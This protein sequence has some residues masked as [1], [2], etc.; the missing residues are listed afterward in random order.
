MLFTVKAKEWGKQ[1]G[2]R[3][4]RGGSEE[5]K[6]EE[7]IQ[8]G[9]TRATGGHQQ[10]FCSVK[11]FPEESSSDW[12]WLMGNRANS[13]FFPPLS[14]GSS[15]LSHEWCADAT[16]FVRFCA[17]LCAA[18][19]LEPA[20]TS[21][22][23]KVV[24]NSV[25]MHKHP[26]ICTLSVSPCTLRCSSAALAQCSQQYGGHKYPQNGKYSVL[27]KALVLGISHSA[28]PSGIWATLLG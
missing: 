26:C 10:F 19:V 16:L 11:R 25:L 13:C 20:V 8:C 14:H 2:G 15:F 28:E 27:E 22:L 17:T 6:G 24:G 21:V 7:I 3:K 1:E 5:G 23:E 18:L 9:T 12:E 4:V